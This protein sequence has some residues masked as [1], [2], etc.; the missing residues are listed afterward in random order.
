MHQALK[1][2]KGLIWL[3]SLVHHGPLYCNQGQARKRREV[4]TVSCHFPSRLDQVQALATPLKA[5]G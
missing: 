3:L 1:G 5:S 2:L 4:Y